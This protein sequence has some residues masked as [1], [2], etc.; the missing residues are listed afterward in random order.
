MADEVAAAFTALLAGHAPA[1]ELDFAVGSTDTVRAGIVE[2]ADAG[3]EDQ[4][5]FDLVLDL[6]A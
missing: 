4:S 5:A 6:A 2:E 3:T 1:T